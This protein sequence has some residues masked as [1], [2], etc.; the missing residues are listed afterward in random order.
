MMEGPIAHTD[1]DAIRHNLSRLQGL[2]SIGDALHPP[3][4]WAVVKAD[5]YGHGLQRVLPALGNADG[6]AVLGLDDVYACRRL[7][8]KKPILLLY[9]CTIT[10]ELSD[11]RLFP[12]HIAIDD[13]QQITAL[14]AMP[15]SA[16]LHAW[17][18]FA[19]QLNHAGLQAQE[20]LQAYQRLAKLTT[21]GRLA[22]LGH[23]QH[24]ANAED[25]DALTHERHAFR[26]IITN[27]PGPVCSENSA[28]ILAT[29]GYA[30]STAWLRAGIA[31]YGIS[32]L[33]DSHGHDMGLK[34]AMTLRAPIYGV[35]HLNTGD[36]LGYGSIFR[37]DQS[38]R[39]GLVRCGYADGY[40]RTIKG[41][42]TCW[43]NGKPARLIGQ[44]SMNTLS[45]D[46]SRHPEAGPGSMVTLW[47]NNGPCIET[48]AKAAGTISAQLCTSLTAQV[49]R[50]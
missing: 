42:G 39:V 29:P 33:P 12:L 21:A 2:S 48:I 49:R 3:K 27:L 16:G 35:Q 24:Y 18:R 45:I 31:L 43:V 22:G 25:P 6:L 47:G 10:T 1:P 8:W 30:A 26:Q 28:S 14:E 46:I 17:L 23:M 20:Y 40:P 7:G 11:A 13:L 19:G 41:N 9:P 32:P 34:P 5:A 4:F 15:G 38:I 50:S 44:V 37:A 36:T